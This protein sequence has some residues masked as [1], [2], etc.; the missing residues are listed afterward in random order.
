[1][2]YA[3]KLNKWL[4]DNDNNYINKVNEYQILYR[5]KKLTPSDYIDINNILCDYSGHDKR[6]MM[7]SCYILLEKVDDFN[8]CFLLLDSTKK[9]MFKEYPIYNLIV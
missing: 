1:L 9:E 4:L 5:C 3:Y 6:M 2:D 8:E 7:C